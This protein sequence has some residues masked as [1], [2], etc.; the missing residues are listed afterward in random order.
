[1]DFGL[2][3]IISAYDLNLINIDEAIKKLQSSIHVIDK[4][5]KW[6]GHLYNWYNTKTLMPLVPEF[7]STVDSGNFIGYL[8]TVKSFLRELKKKIRE[9]ITG[10]ILIEDEKKEIV[11]EIENKKPNIA[12]EEKLNICDNLINI[13][14]NIIEDTSFKY[15]YD[16]KKDLFS[17]GYDLRENHLIDSYYDLLAS[18]A[19]QASFVAIAK[20]DVSYKH[21]FNL[22]RTLTSVD[23]YK[24]L[25]SWA[26]T[27]FEYFMPM[28]IMK[29][30]DYTLMD[31]T[32][33]FC[34]YSQKKYAKKLN[35]PWGIS[36]STFNLQDLNYNYQYKSFGIPWLGVKR[37]L[38][39]E[40]VVSP[41][42]SI[43]TL[44]KNYKDVLK[45]IN[46]LKKIGA[47]DK[48]GFYDAIDYTPNRVHTEDRKAVV[49]T[50][51]AHHQGLILLTINNFINDNILQK[52]F[53][54][55]P[56]I[57]S[58]EILLQEKVPQNIV[59]AKEK[60]EKVE[61]LK[62]VDYEEYNERVIE[63]PE[64]KINILT[65]ENYTL[66]I[67]DKGEGYSTLKDNLIT[68]YNDNIKQANAIYIKDVDNNKF[69]N[70]TIKP[71]D[72]IPD[73]YNV[74]FSPAICKFIRSDNNIETITKI[75]VS[76]IDNVEIRQVEIRNNREEDVNIDIMSYV[77]PIITKKDSD[78]AHP[79]FSNLFLYTSKYKDA[80]IVERRI[81]NKK[82][83]KL[84]YIN[85]AINEQNVDD[86]FELETNKTKFIGREMDMSNPY[87]V[88]NDKIFNN[89]AKIN[90]NTIIAF[91]RSFKI[92][93]DDS[94]K[95]NYIYG[96]SNTKE[97]SIEIFEKYRNV[98]NAERIFDLAI[99]RSLVENR[100]LSQ[101]AKYI[102]EYNDILSS[103]M[104]GS[105]TRKKYLKEILE[106]NLSQEHLWR[107]G[108][109]GV[110]PI[111]LVKIKNVNESE[112]VKELILA[113]EYFA[114]KNIKL[115]LIIL[116][117]EENSYEEYVKDKIY[118]LINSKD[119]NYL[120]N[121]Y[122][123]IYIIKRN[124]ITEAEHNLI[125]ACSDIIFDSRDGLL[126]EQLYE[127][128]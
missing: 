36:E 18:E 94:I 50:Y 56:E 16:E 73:E 93:S 11:E 28:I 57:K 21:W 102:N 12:L 43:M 8:Y 3:A 123:G 113:M 68:R 58:V 79:A 87:V 34:I 128:G 120:L 26:G 67:N 51:M 78:I 22:G 111:I 126:E 6:N 42:S 45:N 72:V 124:H 98:E 31:E 81:R 15:L 101:K 39:E 82:E 105:E 84:Y 29:S 66:V 23:G 10:D 108:I 9:D 110:L 20:H 89:E 70:N 60:K 80:C 103:I 83:E 14:N 100:F 74:I 37:G 35:I 118:E 75:A 85:F 121:A 55:N 63:K 96:V 41:Y 95:I 77:E 106:N 65:N 112:L 40:I 92:K 99:S 90:P 38:K 44:S 5:E 97:E 46:E 49:K 76:S 54:K 1:M 48:Y 109:S 88:I 119:L 2:L 91:K 114:Y 59:F 4:L 24:G 64:G 52:R 27:L 62:Y 19:R 30:F 61:V 17:I 13:I 53:S 32:Y 69:W 115:D 127:D 47:Y 86:V 71:T 104:E 7:I 122:G 125:H 117:E 33:E 107:F 25:I 116:D